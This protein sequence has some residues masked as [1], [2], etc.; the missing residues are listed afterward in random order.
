MFKYLENNP[1]TTVHGF[2][3]FD[4][5][6]ILDDDDLP[7]YKNDEDSDLDKDDVGE[8]NSKASE[9]EASEEYIWS[10]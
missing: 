10:W 3:A 8:E 9:D 2:G 6:G 5:L 4:S 1:Q 7:G